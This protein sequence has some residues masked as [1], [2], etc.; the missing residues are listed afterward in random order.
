MVNC[1]EKE[2]GLLLNIFYKVIMLCARVRVIL[3][4]R[5]GAFGPCTHRRGPTAELGLSEGL[6]SWES[7]CPQLHSSLSCDESWVGSL[8]LSPSWQLNGS[9]LHWEENRVAD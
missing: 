4:S 8:L 9:A 2:S 5:G 1:S 6:S 7:L 3:T